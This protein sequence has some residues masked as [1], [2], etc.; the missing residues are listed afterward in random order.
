MNEEYSVSENDQLTS[1]YYR[2]SEF[3]DESRIQE[4]EQYAVED[5]YVPKE[6]D[7]YSS[8][9]SAARLSRHS[10]VLRKNRNRLGRLL[11]LLASIAGPAIVVI[12]ILTTS[13]FV[14][15]RGYRSEPE[16]LEIELSLY[17]SSE[18]TEFNAV[19]SDRDGNTVGSAM[20]PCR[21]LLLPAKKTALT[22]SGS[23]SA[24]RILTQVSCGRK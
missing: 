2:Y 4:H 13:V 10:S 21:S 9:G 24:R 23:N 14:D 7:D 17:S 6:H 1:E 19:L 12:L 16:S 18:S 22:Q 11:G 5:S 20:F 8:D 3:N 15:V